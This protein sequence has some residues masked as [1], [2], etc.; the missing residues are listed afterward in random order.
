MSKYYPLI[1]AKIKFLQFYKTLDKAG[2][3]DFRKFADSAYFSRGRDFKALLINIEKIK[4]KKLGSKEFISLL[5][6]KL[7]I[8]QR[9]VWNRLHELMKIADSY[10]TQNELKKDRVKSDN[11]AAEYYLDAKAYNLFEQLLKANV[12]TFSK[13]KK[14]HQSFHKFYEILHTRG[15]YYIYTSQNEK[16]AENVTEQAIYHNVSYMIN[17][18]LHLSEMLQLRNITAQELAQKGLSFITDSSVDIFLKTLNENHKDMYHIVNCH[19]QLYRAFLAD[20]RDEF[21]ISALESF[22]KVYNILADNYKEMLYQML[23]NYCIHRTNTGGPQYYSKLFE[24][25]NRKLKDGLYS[26]LKVGNFPINNFRDYIFVALQLGKLDWIK[27]FI[28]KYSPVLPDEVRNDEVNLS[29]GIVNYREGK[30]ANA[31]EYLN[32]VEG[33]NHIHYMDSK[34]YKMRL[35]Y[36]TRQYEDALMEIDNYKHYYRAHKEKIPDGFR[37]TYKSFITEYSKL[38]A[39]K[40][41]EDTEGAEF[42][43]LDLES[44]P[45]TSRRLWIVR[46]LTEMIK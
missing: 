46:K 8:E 22:Y 3:K 25:Y 30:H 21:Y 12:K 29:W 38:M 32:Q 13:S 31:L 15:H 18:Y 41:K 27:W 36:E 4:N 16:Y 33:D 23:I 6:E 14:N 7:G 43:K 5:A 45:Q 37:K 1:L 28:E 2:A 10:I 35:L 19:Y 17:H 39:V 11:L 20:N 24:L 44:K 40:L 42:L 26:D 9:T 34:Y